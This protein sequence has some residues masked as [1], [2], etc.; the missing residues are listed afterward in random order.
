M[1]N[2]SQTQLRRQTF[3]THIYHKIKK[4]I[5]LNLGYAT[6]LAISL[7]SSAGPEAIAILRAMSSTL[8]AKKHPQEPAL[9]S[10]LRT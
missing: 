9:G 3:H 5:G 7:R 1:L 2:T 4:H 10:L 6:A 8:F